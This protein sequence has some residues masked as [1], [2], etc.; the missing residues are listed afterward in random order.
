MKMRCDRPVVLISSCLLG[1]KCNYKAET[2][3]AWQ[4]G[5]FASVKKLVDA[6]VVLVPICPEQM[7]GMTTPRVPSELQGSAAEIFAGKGRILN[8]DGADV[9]DNFLK[10][11]RE[12]AYLAGIFSAKAAILKSKSPSC[13][14]SGI[15]DGTFA[16]RLIDGR[17]MTAQALFDMG[18]RLLDEKDFESAEEI[19]RLLSKL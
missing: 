14:I 1:L 6:G 8:R 5:F 17:G 16:E 19:E 12:A 7:G 9:T 4:K 15:Y 10:G 18:V 3:S 11:A 2:S 13:G